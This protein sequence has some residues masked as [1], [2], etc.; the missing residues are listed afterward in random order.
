M[1]RALL[2]EWPAL[3]VRFP[4][5]MPWHVGGPPELTVHEIDVYVRA[6]R[7]WTRL[8]R[9]QMAQMQQRG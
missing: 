9:E 4:G 7:E 1:R 8:E 3:S 2:P 5:L 6:H